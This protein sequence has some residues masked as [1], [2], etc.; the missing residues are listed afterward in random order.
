MTNEDFYDKEVAPKLME[1]G[2]LCQERGMSFA[3]FVEYSP[4]HFERWA[5]SRRGKPSDP[6]NSWGLL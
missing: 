6:P 3:C 5:S 4:E 1:L 2:T